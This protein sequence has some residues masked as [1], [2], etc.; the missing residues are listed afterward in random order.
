MSFGQDITGRSKGLIETTQSP[1]F[2]PI[3]TV[4]PDVSRVMRRSREVLTQLEQ[5]HQDQRDHLPA[6]MLYIKMRELPFC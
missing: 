1:E 5:S 6:I 3:A 4:P 2:L